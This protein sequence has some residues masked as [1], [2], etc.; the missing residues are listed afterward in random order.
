MNIKRRYG[1]TMTYLTKDERWGPDRS[2]MILLVSR[3]HIL[4]LLVPVEMS[5]LAWAVIER[6]GL[7]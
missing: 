3:S 1:S 5:M 2:D 6:M 4:R 7:L